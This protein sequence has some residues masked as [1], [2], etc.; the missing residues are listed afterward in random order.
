MGIWLLY[1]IATK[2]QRRQNEYPK[3][4]DTVRYL[5]GFA[6]SDI[7]LSIKKETL[8]DDCFTLIKFEKVLDNGTG[9][10]D[11][12]G[13]CFIVYSASFNEDYIKSTQEICK[14]KENVRYV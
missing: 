13:S 1:N 3:P 9:E 5:R 12:S 2:I 8:K 11:K 6:E 7:I 10:I 4:R 14:S